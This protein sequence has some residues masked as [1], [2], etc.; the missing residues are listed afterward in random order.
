MKLYWMIF[1]CFGV[2]W[3]CEKK[4]EK[5]TYYFR[6]DHV[7]KKNKTIF[8]PRL[9]VKHPSGEYTFDGKGLLN[10]LPKP[11]LRRQM[12]INDIIAYM[13]NSKSSKEIK[14][15][16]PKDSD[17]VATDTTGKPDDFEWGMF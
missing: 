6:Y 1:I 10:Q 11:P 3:A 13:K 5:I 4:E 2:A 17:A 9:V 14:K 7:A 8:T 15:D 12:V 16:P